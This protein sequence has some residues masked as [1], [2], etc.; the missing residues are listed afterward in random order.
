MYSAVKI[1]LDEI[2]SY[3]PRIFAQYGS[4]RYRVQEV[5]YLDD[6]DG[7]SW[8]QIQFP[9]IG[10]TVQINDPQSIKTA[11]DYARIVHGIKKNK[12]EYRRLRGPNAEKFSWSKN[13]H[14]SEAQSLKR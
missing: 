5:R 13:E 3:P 2:T 1:E 4:D 8:L 11:R 6:P 14:K 12:K 10:T 7:H 9:D